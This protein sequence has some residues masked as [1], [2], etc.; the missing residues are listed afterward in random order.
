MALGSADA[1][2]YVTSPIY[3]VNGDPH[4]GHA[5]TSLACDVLARFARLEGR[6]VPPGVRLEFFLRRGFPDFSVILLS[7][8]GAISAPGHLL[9]MMFTDSSRRFRLSAWCRSILDLVRRCSS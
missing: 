4:I 9:A 8:F 3:Y 1:P 6:D 5:Y 7:T 2:F